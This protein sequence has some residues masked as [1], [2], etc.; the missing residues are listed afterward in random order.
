MISSKFT[1]L[2]NP[3]HHLVLQHPHRSTRISRAHLQWISMY[4]QPRQSLS[5]SVGFFWR[6]FHTN[7]ITQ[8]HNMWFFGRLSLSIVFL[9][10][11]HVVVC[12]SI[13]NLSIDEQCSIVQ[14]YHILFTHQLRG[15]WV[16]STLGLWWMMLS[17]FSCRSLFSWTGTQEWNCWAVRCTYC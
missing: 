10:S 7:E 14:I 5:V 9:K 12:I 16:V 4:L 8:S 17:T 6:K 3:H 13:F 15:I 2:C 1:E 11:I